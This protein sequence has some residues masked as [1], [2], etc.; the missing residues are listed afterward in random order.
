MLNCILLVAAMATAAIMGAITLI[1]N[2]PEHA[3][4]FK[5][6]QA[7]ASYLK[8]KAAFAITSIN[9]ATNSIRNMLFKHARSL[10]EYGPNL[11]TKAF[12][13]DHL[14]KII[15]EGAPNIAREI[16]KKI[17]IDSSV[18][19]TFDALSQG[20]YNWIQIDDRAINALKFALGSGDYGFNE[21]YL[22]ASRAAENVHALER[23]KGYVGEQITAG[24]LVANGYVVSFPDSP[25]QA[26]YDLLVDGHPVQVKTT[27]MD[28]DIH[29]ALALHPDIPVMVPTEL[30]DSMGGTDNVIFTPGFS[31]ELAE[32]VTQD[33]IEAITDLGN[34]MP[35]PIFTLGFIGYRKIREVSQG[36][37][38]KMAIIEGSVELGG[39]TIVGGLGGFVGL[40]AGVAAG[41]AGAAVGKTVGYG[42]AAAI[43]TL[44]TVKGGKVGA[45][46]GGLAFL[47]LGPL[48]AVAV[49]A[50]GAL[51]GAMIGRHLGMKII[52]A[53]KL[54][55]HMEVIEPIIQSACRC[56]EMLKFGLEQRIDALI[57]KENKVMM[58]KIIPENKRADKIIKDKLSNLFEEDI[59]SVNLQILDIDALKEKCFIEESKGIDNVN[60]Y[61]KL[62]DNFFQYFN[63]YSIFYSNEFKI[64]INKFFYHVEKFNFFMK[65]RKLISP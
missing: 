50:A 46:A 9:E 65:E 60:N 63:K 39:V 14:Q 21:I 24:D 27:L 19:L 2:I 47:V 51:G 32:Q 59:K 31:H 56:I 7:Y 38:I 54:R 23:F 57:Q 48:G 20:F 43:G 6:L 34:S 12:L 13:N 10:I 58:E 11:K 42:A 33:N 41:A 16:N 5:K 18:A 52:E 36:K 62:T 44:M 49:G 3:D 61:Y 30:M 25:T 15:S 22:S 17:Q 4:E 26:G 55:G 53:W 37:N 40:K 45:L 29:E 64:E 35:I 28:A 1:K 8:G